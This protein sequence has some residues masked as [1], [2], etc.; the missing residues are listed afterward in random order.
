MSASGEPSTTNTASHIRRIA[1]YGVGIGLLVA[2]A[3]YADPA[4]IFSAF[5]DISLGDLALLALI[6]FLLILVSVVKW[7]AFLLHLGISATLRRLFGL[8]LLGYFVNLLMPSVLGGDVVRSLYVAKDAD[9]AHSVSATLLERYT[10]LMAMLLMAIVGVWWAPHVTDPIKLVVVVVT[11]GALV[12]SGF[13]FS[14]MTTWL[15]ECLR[16]PER[17]VSLARKVEDGL[18]FGIQNKRLV[19]RALVLS[20]LF[21]MLTVANTAAA[22]W[23]VGWDSIPVGE[24]FVV[25]PLILLVGAIPISP[26]GLGLQE[27]AFVFFLHSLGCTTGQALA[28]ALL[29]RAK[30]YVLAVFGGL[31]WLR[32]RSSP[33]YAAETSVTPRPLSGS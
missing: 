31:A 7:Q 18:V 13:L 20:F 25:V 3:I 24:L 32:L 1:R 14:R 23:A 16:I 2:L 27:G 9:R 19:V 33:E 30:S 4:A 8:Y 6:S 15:M 11:L 29:L 28:L 10:G 12:G 17:F 21:H 22:G 5:K 26:Q